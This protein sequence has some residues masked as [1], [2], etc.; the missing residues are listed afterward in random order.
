MPLYESTRGLESLKT[1]IERIAAAYGFTSQQVGLSQ[2]S[3]ASQ[4]S[5]DHQTATQL[6]LIQAKAKDGYA[7]PTAVWGGAKKGHSTTLAFSILSAK[8]VIAHALVVKAA[9]SIAELIGYTD[10]TLNLS[11]I[12]DQESRRRFTRELTNYFRKNMNDA[13]ED[14]R[15]LAARDPLAAYHELIKRD[16]ILEKLPR[17]IDSLSESSRKTMLDTLALFESVGIEY[18]ISPHLMGTPLVQSE[19]LF[20]I[21]GTNKKGEKE[22]IARGGRVDDYARK[23]M[24]TGLGVSIAITVPAN[25]EYRDH[26]QVLSC[27]VVHV[28]EAAKHKAFALMEALWRAELAVGQALLSDNLREQMQLAQKNGATYVG[29]IGQ[30]ESIDGTVLVRHLTSLV[31]ESIPQTKL[32]SYLAKKA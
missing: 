12:G 4:P 18:T 19:L 32:P 22:V 23:F 3:V 14:I 7:A 15:T 28:G 9:M 2:K 29:I 6:A 30:R 1:S 21:T 11:S 24:K 25:I 31:Q 13:P 27:F 5:N 26:P 10:I 17:P 20:A 16:L 8:H